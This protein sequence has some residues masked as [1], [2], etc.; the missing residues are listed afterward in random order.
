MVLKTWSVKVVGDGLLGSLPGASG[1]WAR[2]GRPVQSSGAA[3]AVAGEVPA[4][5]PRFASIA[6]L[7]WWDGV[8]HA[9]TSP[10]SRARHLTLEIVP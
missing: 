6:H 1:G 7:A 3:R 4:P 2:W 10:G 9:V 8:S 5:R